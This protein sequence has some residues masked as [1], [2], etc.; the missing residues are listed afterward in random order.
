MRRNFMVRTLT[1][2]AALTLATSSVAAAQVDTRFPTEIGPALVT[3][4]LTNS[5]DASEMNELVTNTVK[6]YHNAGLGGKVKKPASPKKDD[7][8]EV[9]R[10]GLYTFDPFDDTTAVTRRALDLAGGFNPNL[11]VISGGEWQANVGI[12][13]A[14]SGTVIVDLHQPASCL[15]E[16][17]QPDATGECVGAVPS[18]YSAVDFAVE[19]GAYLAG[20]VAARESRDQPLGI[21][22]GYAG[23]VECERYVTGFVNGALSVAPD[24]EIIRAY[25]ADDEVSGFGDEASAK[26][27]AEAFLDVYQPSV[28]MPVGRATNM[29]MVEAACEAG[30]MVIGTGVD[31]GTQ[32]PDLDCVMASI[33]T[34]TKRA[35]EEAMFF[36]STGENTPLTRYDINNGGVSVTDEWRLATTKRVDTNDFYL[37]AET[38]LRTGQVL[39]CPDGCSGTSGTS[40]TG[41]EEDVPSDD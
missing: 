37:E 33:T 17:G 34:D 24:I 39:P 15:S 36:F 21:I 30:V 26:T 12:A 4:V 23:C 41:D 38:A 19:E 2:A 9:P 40:G 13:R 18:N 16:N 32:R 27:Y 11:M 5:L 10:G 6:S 1:A 29:G 22:S 28:L 25:L 14:N 35:I 20:V 31:I 8:K 3:A 7:D